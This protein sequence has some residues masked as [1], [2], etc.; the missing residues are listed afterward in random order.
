M[1]TAFRTTPQPDTIF[2]KNTIVVMPKNPPLTRTSLWVVFWGVG[3]LMG[4]FL[5]SLI[6][7]AADPR[8]Q[9]EAAPAAAQVNGAVPTMEINVQAVLQLPTAT[10]TPVRP[11]SVPSAS[12]TPT[13]NDCTS[14][15]PGRICQVPFP[16]PPTATPFPSCEEMAT[17]KPGSWCIWPTPSP[18]G[19]GVAA[20]Q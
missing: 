10:P 8:T 11:T 6:D 9:A 3:I 13:I 4:L 12:L 17:L 5:R 19:A 7:V 15:E 20:R 14:A 2:P 16:P 18:A 1:A